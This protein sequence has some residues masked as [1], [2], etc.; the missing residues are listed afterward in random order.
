MEDDPVIGF[1]KKDIIG[2]DLPQNDARII[3]IQ[4]AQAMVD[5]IHADKG[6]AA[7]IQ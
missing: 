4:M 2:L 1:Q 3:N 6:I 5:W 7:N